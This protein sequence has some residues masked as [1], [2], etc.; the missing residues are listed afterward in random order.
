[1]SEPQGLQ[2]PLSPETTHPMSKIA[3]LSLGEDARDDAGLEPTQLITLDYFQHDGCFD[4]YA[5]FSQNGVWL[6]ARMPL[7]TGTRVAL[8]LVL[9][10][11]FAPI[12]LRGTV[13]GQRP[14]AD[15]GAPWMLVWFDLARGEDHLLF[16]AF[17]REHLSN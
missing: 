13:A 2:M 4:D 16:Q 17:L 9:P 5:R 6:R 7:P 10:D 14:D 11:L 15:G 3:R 1:M 12:N 8:H